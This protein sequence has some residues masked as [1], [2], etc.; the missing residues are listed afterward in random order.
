MKVPSGLEC[1][2][3]RYSMVRARKPA[4]PQDGSQITSVGCG[5]IISIIASMIWRGVRNWPLMPAVVSLLSR[6]S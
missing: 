2:R 4:V 3:L 1:T 6:Y 5:A